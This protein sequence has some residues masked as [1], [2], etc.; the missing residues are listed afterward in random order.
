MIIMQSGLNNGGGTNGDLG[1]H[2]AGQVTWAVSILQILRKAVQLRQQGA[3][4]R[5]IFAKCYVLR[6]IKEIVRRSPSSN[7][8]WFEQITIKLSPTLDEPRANNG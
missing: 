1:S 8:Q 7:K 6:R 2:Q 5:Y 3:K 4:P